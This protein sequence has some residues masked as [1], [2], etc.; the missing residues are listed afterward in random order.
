MGSMSLRLGRGGRP[1]GSGDGFHRLS[2][3]LVWILEGPFGADPGLKSLD[4]LPLGPGAEQPKD[5]RPSDERPLD[6]YQL[7]RMRLV[8]GLAM[9]LDWERWE[10]FQGSAGR[11]R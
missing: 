2:S 8:T 1:L 9:S 7:T 3:P 6:E 4:P 11:C 10:R 5:G